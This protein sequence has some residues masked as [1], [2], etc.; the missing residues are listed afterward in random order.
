MYSNKAP[1]LTNTP[2]FLDD[3][4]EL[5][6]VQNFAPVITTLKL[7]ELYFM[8]Y[9]PEMFYKGAFFIRSKL[10]AFTINLLEVWGTIPCPHPFSLLQNLRAF[11]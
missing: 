10:L 2:H 9:G 8:N 4:I 5:F 11:I 6:D 7:M 1:S 3:K